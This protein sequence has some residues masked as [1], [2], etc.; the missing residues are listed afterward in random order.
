MRSTIL[1]DYI[2]YLQESD[3][4]MGA[5]N[6]PEIFSQAMSC[7]ESDIWYN[8]IKEEMISMKSNDVWDLVEFLNRVR[9]IGYKWIYETKKDSLGNIERHKARLVAK[10][11]TQKEGIDY[12]KTFSHVSKKRFSSCNFGISSIFHHGVATNGCE[13]CI[14]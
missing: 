3:Y 12:M 1:S 8:A 5:E 14:S 9:A 4:N 6:D 13:N 10:G 7:K 11:Y 2:M